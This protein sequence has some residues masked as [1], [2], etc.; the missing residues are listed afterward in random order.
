MTVV[1]CNVRNKPKE[2]RGFDIETVVHQWLSADDLRQMKQDWLMSDRRLQD[3]WYL[4]PCNA[5][6]R[7]SAGAADDYTPE[8]LA[9]MAIAVG[10]HVRG[11]PQQLIQKVET[12]LKEAHNETGDN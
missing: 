3:N 8:E 4:R 2:H 6:E 12:K 11:I 1:Q 9:D 5:E 7:E 10:A